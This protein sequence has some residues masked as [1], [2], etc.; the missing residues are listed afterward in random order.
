MLYSCC[1][2][3]FMLFLCCTTF[4]FSNFFSTQRLNFQAATDAPTNNATPAATAADAAD[5]ATTG[6]M[7]IYVTK[8]T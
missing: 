2:T 7:G 3:F 6:K 8:I 4:F 1:T 5:P